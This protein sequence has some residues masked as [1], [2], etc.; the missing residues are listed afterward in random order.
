[1]I[2]PPN[3]GVEVWL[4]VEPVDFRKQIPGLAA[5]VQDTLAMDPFSAQPRID[6]EH[7][8]PDHERTCP[9]HGVELERFGEVT[10]EQLDVIP[11][12]IR[13]LRHVRGK[14]RCPHCEGH[15]RT[16]PMPAQPLPKR[17]RQPRAARPRGHRE[18]TPMPCRCTASTSNS[19]AS[20]WTSRAPRWP[21]GWCVPAH[22]WSLSS[23]CCAMNCS[24]A[25]TC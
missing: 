10:S 2:R 5:L 9:H 4:C 21:R 12:T 19:S 6:V 15:L 25:P 23:T 16:A 8:L 11:A 14:Y 1:M 7:P 13:V 20:A 24:T 22:S 3:E 17:P 18:S